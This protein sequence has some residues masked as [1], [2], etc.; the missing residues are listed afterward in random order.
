ML[1]CRVV[2]LGSNSLNQKSIDTSL[3]KMTIRNSCDKAPCQFK[4]EHVYRREPVVPFPA[5][6]AGFGSACK[7]LER[8]NK[9]GTRFDGISKVLRALRTFEH[10]S[11]F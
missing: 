8:R 6:V 1:Y 4:G 11:A 5:C 7:A 10:A 9:T 2:C 3:C